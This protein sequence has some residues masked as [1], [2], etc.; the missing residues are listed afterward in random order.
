[1]ILL[2]CTFCHGI[3]YR[4]RDKNHTHN[5]ERIPPQILFLVGI[6]WYY[7]TRS[8]SFEN[9]G[10][11]RPVSNR[12]IGQVP[13]RIRCFGS[14]CSLSMSFQVLWAG[15]IVATHRLH[16]GR[17]MYLLHTRPWYCPSDRSTYLHHIY[18]VKHRQPQLLLK[19]TA[20]GL[21]LN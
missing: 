18:E 11:N 8:I 16:E 10:S 7:L 13:Y 3:R 5:C 21:L 17:K 20:F 14:A 6:V 12:S 2:V 19:I 9:L 4:L 15:S 1:M